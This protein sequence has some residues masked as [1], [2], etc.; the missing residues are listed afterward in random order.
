MK[1]ASNNDCLIKEYLGYD[2]KSGFVF[3]KKSRGNKLKIG[4]VAGSLHRTGYLSLEFLGKPYMVHRVS[5][6]LNYGCWPN[7]QIDHINGIRTDNRIDNLRDV[8]PRENS[9]NCKKHRN[10]N[11]PGACFDKS[12]NNYISSIY[13]NKKQYYL[14][15]FK[16]KEDAAEYYEMANS[17]V[18]ENK[19]NIDLTAKEFREY[20]KKEYVRRR[21]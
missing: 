2:K 16:K 8:S 1:Q 11:A 19:G 3:W 13:V 10:G 6:L 18:L 17:L 15:R 7:G 5:W 21:G 12:Q 4:S 20:L 9:K 14:G